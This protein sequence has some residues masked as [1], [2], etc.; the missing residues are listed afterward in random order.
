MRR[1]ARNVT[2]RTQLESVQPSCLAAVASRS[3]SAVVRR[4]SRRS[5]SLDFMGRPF[6]E[7]GLSVQIARERRVVRVGVDPVGQRVELAD[8]LVER[9]AVASLIQALH[10]HKGLDECA[11]VRP[12]P[13]RRPDV[14]SL[15]GS[16]PGPWARSASRRPCV[17][18]GRTSP[19]LTREPSEIFGQ[20]AHVIRV[21]PF[22]ARTR[23][24]RE[25]QAC[26]RP[27][28]HHQGPDRQGC[29]SEGFSWL[30][31]HYSCV[32]GSLFTISSVR[33][34]SVRV[35]RKTRKIG[36]CADG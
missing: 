22:D 3:C 29:P 21:L 12:S 11:D 19:A 34:P 10:F 18:E 30:P 7:K 35:K 25:G 23:P 26:H 20:R 17:D 9:R 32:G 36:D 8:Q 24:A 31:S 33:H 6:R 1:A 14:V 28:T 16:C 5:A 27:G 2:R 4:T 15:Q 13:V